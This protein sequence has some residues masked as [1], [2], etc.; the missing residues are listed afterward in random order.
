MNIQYKRYPAEYQSYPMRH[1]ENK[2]LKLHYDGYYKSVPIQ[3]KR[4]PMI[5]QYM[6]ALIETIQRHFNQYSKVFAVRVDLYFPSEWNESQRVR[7]DYYTRFMESLKAKLAAFNYRKAQVGDG[8]SNTVRFCR[9][10]EYGVNRGLHIHAVLLFNGH[11]FR[12]LGSYQSTEENLY[13]R[14]SGAWA[15]A[16][17]LHPAHVIS[18]GLVHFGET[19]FVERGRQETADQ[20]KQLFSHSAYLCKADTKRFDIPVKVFSRSRG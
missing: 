3:T 16:L 12:G 6:D 8:R 10:Y 18:E 4:G 17:G 20:V 9:A 13:H 5:T 2:E 1:P 14:I 11:V 7:L 19:F 15:S